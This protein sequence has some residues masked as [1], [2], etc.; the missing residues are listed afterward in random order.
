MDVCLLRTHGMRRAVGAPVVSTLLI[1]L[2][3][4]V[5]TFTAVPYAPSQL[6]YSSNSIGSFAYLLQT[7]GTSQ[8]ASTE[9]ITWNVSGQINTASPSYNILMDPLPFQLDEK[10]PA[11]V[12]VI[13]QHGVIKMFVGNCQK[14]LDKA[15][16]WQFTPDTNSSTGDGVWEKLTV[17]ESST[18]ASVDGPNYLSAGFAYAATNTSDSSVYAFGGMCPF[19]NA[20]ETDWI[21]AANYSQSMIVLEPSG[22]GR[23]DSYDASTTG[24]RAPPIAEAG[25]TITPL[26]ATYAYSSSGEV[27]QQQDFLLIGGQTQEAFINMSQLAVFS[28]PQNSWSFVTVDTASAPYKTELAARGVSTAEPR[29][30]HTAVLSPDGSKVIVYGGWVGN[31]S[32]AAQPQLVILELGETYGGSGDWSWSIL[33]T[34][35]TEIAGGGGLYGHG[36]TMLPGGVMM[37]AGG[38]SIPHSSSLSTSKRSATPSQPNTQV[39]LYNVTSEKWVSSY[40]NP[41]SIVIRQHSSGSGSTAWKTGLGVGVGLGVPVVA[42][43]AIL[44]FFLSRRRQKRRSRDRELRKLALGA[45]RAHFWGRDEPVMASSIRKPAMQEADVN[46]DYPWTANRGFGR[47]SIWRDKGDAVA[48]RTGL[49]GDTLNPTTTGRS[50][51]SARMYRPPTQYSEYRRSDATGDIHPIDER[52]EDE[53]KDAG[54]IV[55]QET[56]DTFRES[57]FLTPL[58]TTVCGESYTTGSAEPSDYIAGIGFDRDLPSS[59]DRDGRTSSNLSDSSASAKSMHQSRIINFSYTSSQPS[60]GRQSPQ[61]IASMSAL[62][63]EPTR[64]RANSAALSFEKRY[65]SDSYSTAQTT[66]SQRQAEGEHLLRE[67]P[68]S[69]S[70]LDLFPKPTTF[71][72]QRA[73]EWIGSNVRRVLSLTRRRPTTDPDPT[74]AP[75]ASGIDRRSILLAPTPASGYGLPRRSVSASAELFRHKQGARDWGAGNRLSR[76]I[77]SQVRYSRDDSALHGFLDLGPDSDEDWDVEGAAEGRRVQVT[78]TVPKEKL[79]VVNATAGELDNFSEKSVSRSNSDAAK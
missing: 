36:A 23:I 12:S 50:G 5:P 20:S 53:A 10:S 60:S 16:M 61:K 43:I 30:G 75:L 2:L 41:D 25:F 67:D 59:P 51:L 78:F 6:L 65:S 48:E 19:S 17:M 40:Q 73:S 56:I 22:S 44:I 35:E 46:N 55:T 39:Y 45:E 18:G 27:R 72:K 11:F 9:F 1:L 15:G 74:T 57:T 33:S 49:L 54:R 14:A 63:R 34:E 7:T 32:V 37:V 3:L 21:A 79:R 28:L 69:S 13:D 26:Q 62:S 24:I 4:V 70:P 77:E 31:T 58:S 38:Y 66:L 71:P 52:E 8:D 42:G 68:E 29:S 64:S 47:S 76:N